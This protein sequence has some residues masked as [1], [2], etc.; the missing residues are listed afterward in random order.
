MSGKR[1]ALITSFLLIL[2]C[3]YILRL[4]LNE[5][6]GYYIHPR[7]MIFTIVMAVI[8][9]MV[10][11]VELAYTLRSS[12]PFSH[13]K[14]LN[15]VDYTLII[16]LCFAF[17]LPAQPLSQQTTN[18]KNINT[19]TLESPG[20]SDYSDD[21]P[22]TTDVDSIMF[23]TYYLNNYTFDC[24][25]GKQTTIVGYVL[26]L[27]ENELPE[28][29]YYVGRVVVACCVIDARPYAFVVQSDTPLEAT[30]PETWLKVSG[31]LS[32]EVFDGQELPVI[33]AT[34]I[35][36]TANPEKPYDYIDEPATE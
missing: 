32:K 29:Y 27:P 18:R 14:A 28:N 30:D 1:K 17:L 26:K 34:S 33:Q 9:L 19:P 12:G 36:Q 16:V 35:E 10:L 31:T 2:F 11:I 25:D 24:F 22:T 5:N 23:W 3:V 20:S 7:Y 4:A 15:L 21:C 6:L 13:E 8:A